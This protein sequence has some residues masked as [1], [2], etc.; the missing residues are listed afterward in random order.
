MVSASFSVVLGYAS[1][2]LGISIFIIA[3]AY[4]AGRLLGN[5]RYLAFAKNL[6]IDTILVMA[7]LFSYTFF[8][9]IIEN[10]VSSINPQ[11]YGVCIKYK[12][13]PASDLE[14]F[15]DPIPASM[16]CYMGSSIAYL[17]SLFFE[18]KYMFLQMTVIQTANGLI[19]T[20]HINNPRNEIRSD[21][22]TTGVPI[23]GGLARVTTIILKSMASFLTNAALFVFFQKYLL[24]FFYYAGPFIFGLGLFLRFFP[25]SRKVGGL[26]MAIYL[27]IIFVFP[28]VYNLFYILYLS[29]DPVKATNSET[30]LVRVKFSILEDKSIYNG[31]NLKSPIEIAN[32]VEESIKK[33]TFGE[34]LDNDMNTLYEESLKDQKKAEQD[35]GINPNTNSGSFISSIPDYLWKIFSDSVNILDSLKS[36]WRFIQT[37]LLV[38]GRVHVVM[39]FQTDLLYGG[40]LGLRGRDMGFSLLDMMLEDTAH[41]V[42]YTYLSSFIAALATI[43]AI[44][45]LSPLLGGDIEIAGLTHFV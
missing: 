30:R 14:L 20:V 1:F 18:I 4:M 5:E 35:L 16:P 41:I 26:L 28:L 36:I 43:A 44:K 13:L 9:P 24:L 45:D 23:F 38:V 2:G 39:F 34:E 25:I 6:L 40:V 33:G 11:G 27:A 15:Q 29:N 10:L 8:E 22:S 37:M 31:L 42:F 12:S 17:D 19:E 3:L 7:I 32:E 21:F